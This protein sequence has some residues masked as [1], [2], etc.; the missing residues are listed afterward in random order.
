MQ[1]TTT[2][3]KRLVMFLWDRRAATRAGSSEC[4]AIKQ[5]LLH[6]F[7]KTKNHIYFH[8]YLHLLQSTFLLFIFFYTRLGSTEETMKAG[9]VTH[10]M[11]GQLWQRLVRKRVSSTRQSWG[12]QWKRGQQFAHAEVHSSAK[13]CDSCNSV[14]FG[15]KMKWKKSVETLVSK[16][17][18]DTTL[19]KEADLR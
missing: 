8:I 7:F 14:Q 13:N 11:E 9:G 4:C 1:T 16:L 10:P 6:L 2:T 3:S 18:F 5:W 19:V 15:K 12:L 17:T